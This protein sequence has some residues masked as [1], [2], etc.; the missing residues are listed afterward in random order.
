M[1][2]PRTPGQAK[3][4]TTPMFHRC[5]P[6]H[7]DRPPGAAPLTFAATSVISRLDGPDRGS[8]GAIPRVCHEPEHGHT[9][10][11]QPAATCHTMYV[12]SITRH[13]EL[14]K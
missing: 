1:L 9:S 7:V 6:G 14:A 3:T 11:H 8:A 12:A 5:C 4:A 2:R 10:R 13:A